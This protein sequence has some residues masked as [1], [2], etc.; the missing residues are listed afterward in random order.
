M[1]ICVIVMMLYRILQKMDMDATTLHAD[2]S[3]DIKAMRD[4]IQIL[5]MKKAFNILCADPQSH[6]NAIEM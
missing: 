5:K 6:H 4:Q 2:T 3:M 1:A